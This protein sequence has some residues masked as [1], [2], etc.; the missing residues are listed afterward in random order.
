[1]LPEPKLAVL[2]LEYTN[3][4]GYTTKMEKYPVESATYSE[5]DTLIEEFANFLR[6]CG[7]AGVEE[8]IYVND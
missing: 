5:L 6:A 3:Q 7:F 1:M 4:F 8:H 2:K